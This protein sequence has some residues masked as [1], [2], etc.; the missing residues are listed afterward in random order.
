MIYNGLNGTLVSKVSNQIL[1]ACKKTLTTC[2]HAG[3]FLNGK[4][5]DG[6]HHSL[7]GIGEEP[8]RFAL[9]L[10]PLACRRGYAHQT[11][12]TFSSV[13]GLLKTFSLD[14]ISIL[15]FDCHLDFYQ[16][17]P[18]SPDSTD[19]ADSPDSPDSPK[20]PDSPESLFHSIFLNSFHLS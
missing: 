18:D 2:L 1:L 12:L 15:Y 3:L 10:L 8:A 13:S 11:T 6:K 16:E 9:V 14:L 17:S 20:L 7:V 19:L 4:N 5:L